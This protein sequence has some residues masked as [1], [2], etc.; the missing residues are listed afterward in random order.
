M[1]SPSP[2]CCSCGPWAG[3]LP[4]L[5]GPCAVTNLGVGD[6]I[7]AVHMLK[8]YLCLSER[9]WDDSHYVFSPPPA[10]THIAFAFGRGESSKWNVR[11]W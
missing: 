9:V 10:K 4:D 3:T 2:R 1:A 11:K 8:Y 7:D 6:E 5:S